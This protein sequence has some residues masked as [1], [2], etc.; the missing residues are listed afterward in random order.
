MGIFARRAAVVSA[1]LTAVETKDI[2]GPVYFCSSAALVS[3]PLTAVETK[4]IHGDGDFCSSAALVSAP[5]TAVE[6]LIHHLPKCA[7]KHALSS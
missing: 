6:P 4:D 5:L 7:C 3:A 1:P 2:H